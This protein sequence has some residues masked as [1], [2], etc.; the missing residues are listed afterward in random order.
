MFNYISKKQH[1]KLQA[2]YNNLLKKHQELE[3]HVMGATRDE[4]SLTYKDAIQDSQV[5]L[6]RYAD[7]TAMLSV[8]APF[9][10][11][12]KQSFK[13]RQM[14]Q[15]TVA[16]VKKK[17]SGQTLKVVNYNKSDYEAGRIVCIKY[18]K[19]LKLK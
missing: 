4:T 10:E 5:L 9:I 11:F 17:Q 16:R 13:E 6:T 1:D 15:K 14:K 19:S 8:V 2:D 18:Q 3:L 7:H 12:L